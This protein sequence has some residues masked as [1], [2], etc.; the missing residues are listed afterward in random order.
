M[1]TILI[2]EDEKAISNLIKISLNSSGYQ[3]ETA[4]DGVQAADMIE[5]KRYDL[6]ILDI[7]LPKI[8]G[9]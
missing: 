8:D 7:M 5:T 4:Y 1:N 3:C 2:V 6:I 9:Y